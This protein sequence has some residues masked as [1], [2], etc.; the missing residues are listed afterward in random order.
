M[1]VTLNGESREVPDGL[2]VAALLA[3]L[4]VPAE[5]VAV[6][7]NREVLPRAAW[8]TTQVQPNDRYEVVHLVGGG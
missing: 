5:R 6:E 7:R 1:N 2:T 3:H 4:R 8:E